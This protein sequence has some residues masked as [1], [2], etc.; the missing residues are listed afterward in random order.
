M[1]VRDRHKRCED[2]E[3]TWL[4]GEG[5][6][7]N[8]CVS[9]GALAGNCLFLLV[10]SADSHTHTHTRSQH[11]LLITPRLSDC[12]N[13]RQIL[14]SLF[15]HKPLLQSQILDTNR[16]THHKWDLNNTSI[17]QK[18]WRLLSVS[19][20]I[21]LSSR[22]SEEISVTTMLRLDKIRTYAIK[23]LNVNWNMYH[24]MIW[25][26]PHSFYSSRFY[27]MNSYSRVCFFLFLLIKKHNFCV[28]YNI[29][30]LNEKHISVWCCI[31]VHL[32]KFECCGK[33]NLFQ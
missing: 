1:R 19:Q 21:L 13:H 14:P 24:Q 29:N 3:V 15:T 33:V 7:R 8:R 11:T 30:I 5:R 22:V 6:L 17:K 27:W 26:A 12:K 23:R 4:S 25:A 32:N 10:S 16:K 20:M 9:S 31:Q 2:R 28:I 18:E